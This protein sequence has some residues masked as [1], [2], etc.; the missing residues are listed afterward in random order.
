MRRI[1]SSFE[2]RP[3]Q[4]IDSGLVLPRGILKVDF[5]A[6][7]AN[8]TAGNGVPSSTQGVEF[9]IDLFEPP[10]YIRILPAVVDAKQRDPRRGYRKIAKDIGANYMQVK[11]AWR[12]HLRMLAEGLSEPY[13]ELTERPVSASRWRH[14]R[15]K[16]EG[17]TEDAA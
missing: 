6:I 10:E 4:N 8:S 17:P 1:I 13:R 7:D 2:I 12:L 15:Q 3:I 16:G 5:S 9:V 14:R 11:R